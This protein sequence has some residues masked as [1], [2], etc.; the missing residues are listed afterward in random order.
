MASKAPATVDAPNGNGN[1]LAALANGTHDPRRNGQATPVLTED[2]RRSL[3]S[4][5]LLMRAIEERGNSLYRQGK[6]PGS[7]YDGRGQE[8]V[9]VGATFALGPKDPVSSPLIRDLGAHLV[10]GTDVTAIFL[11]TWVGRAA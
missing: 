9:S 4:H 3:L 2:D 10:K 11:T 5:M 8:A 1:G 7:F 6:V